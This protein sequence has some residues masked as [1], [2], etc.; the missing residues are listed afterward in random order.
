MPG[1]LRNVWYM[2]AWAG[3]IGDDLF[4]RRVAGRPV[5]IFRTGGGALAALEDRCPHRFAPL[6]RG[7]RDGDRIVCGYHG[8]TYD[9]GGRCV[10]NSLAGGIPKRAQVPAFPVVERDGIAW[11]WL[12]AP[13]AADP[14]SIPDYSFL[15]DGPANRTVRGV[16][17]L[18]ANYEYGTDNLMD[19]SHIEFVHKG[20]F[21][22]R[23][24]IFAG[25]HEVRADGDTLWSNWWMPDVAAPPHTQGVYPPEQRC[26]HWLDMRWNAPASM[27]LEVGATPHGAPREQGYA[28]LQAHVVTPETEHSSHYFWASSRA[29][30]VD[31]PGL[32][33]MLRQLF[34][35]AFA[36]EDKP[37]IEAAYANVR[38]GDRGPGFWDQQAAFLPSD[39]GGARARRAIEALLRRE[40]PAE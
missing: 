34:E 17:P 37:I 5:L 8:L 16:M 40:Q 30:E 12:G 31:N 21:A 18:A 15:P 29:V 20:S 27:R 10:H 39:A 13:E 36:E 26:D 6:S 22:G 3:E 19:L 38:Y 35:Q 7:T 2:A 4:S 14:A 1:F 23:G 32:D 11:V 9:A 28:V 33:A 24:V 25:R